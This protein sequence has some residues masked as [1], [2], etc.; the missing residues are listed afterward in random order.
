MPARFD[1]RV[2]R[3]PQ[4][5]GDEAARLQDHAACAAAVQ[6]WCK[7]AGPGLAVASVT[8]S[9]AA[10]AAPTRSD[11]AADLR[12]WADALC[13]HL[14]GGSRLDRLGRAAGLAWRLRT[15]LADAWPAWRRADDPWDAGWALSD[16]VALAHWQAGWRPRRPTLLLAGGDAAAALAPVLGRLATQAGGPGLPLCWLWVG[17]ALPGPAG[18]RNQRFAWDAPA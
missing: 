5:R 4:A 12:A 18:V 7:A 11:P 3:P 9:T 2:L 1:T 10:A 6:A 13:R 16:P 15:V 8:A 17:A 14:D